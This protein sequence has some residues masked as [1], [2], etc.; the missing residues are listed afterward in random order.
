MQH[1]LPLATTPALLSSDLSLV[2]RL[3]AAEAMNVR[4]CVAA[5]ASLDP[6][7]DTAVLEVGG[8]T[9]L[10]AGVGSPMTH[11]MG[12]GVDAED[13]LDDDAL[14]RLEAFYRERQ[15]PALIDLCP[16]CDLAL[17][18]RLS[19]R[20]YR[21]VELNNVMVRSLAA[22][23]LA[24]DTRTGPTIREV[25]ADKADAW[26][27]C[28]MGGFMEGAIPGEEVL[29]FGKLLFHMETGAA[30]FA[31]LDGA[32]TATAGMALQDGVALFFGDATLPPSRGRGA[33]AALI[34]H[35]LAHA[36]ARGANL[37]MVCVLPGSIS[38]RN[39]ERAGFQL[40]YTRAN[41]MRSWE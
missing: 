38:H 28:M 14:D 26:A 6:A 33:Q 20:G 35:R 29:A 32:D 21:V 23:E 13:P 30:F 10:F 19:A 5:Y 37:A 2:R 18:A 24:D 39:Y 15:S 8:G 1:S 41:L 34:R 36:A 16:V 25:S 4:A 11:A 22:D 9:A 27:T 12:V 3:E 40:V 17:V 7:L 31:T